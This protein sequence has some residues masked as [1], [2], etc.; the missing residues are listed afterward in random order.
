MSWLVRTTNLD[1]DVPISGTS[2]SRLKT[3]GCGAA[4]GKRL[5]RGDAGGGPIQPLRRRAFLPRQGRH[6]R[7]VEGIAFATE[8][9]QQP[10]LHYLR[11]MM[12]EER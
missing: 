3:G 9:A 7:V 10:L 1:N 4:S 12:K 2:L 5:L 6:Y 8:L 11:A